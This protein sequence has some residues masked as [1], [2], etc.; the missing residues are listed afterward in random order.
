MGLFGLFSKKRK[1]SLKELY[2]PVLD[3]MW[4]CAFRFKPW[5]PKKNQVVF[6]EV[7]IVRAVAYKEGIYV[8]S[9]ECD[10]FHKETTLKGYIDTI[11]SDW[12][13]VGF[14]E[15]LDKAKAE[16]CKLMNEWIAEM[17][18]MVKNAEAS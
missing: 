12:S 3:R 1:M 16:Y 10:P 2:A 9:D 5:E 13:W 8:E 15:S 11:T 17:Q 6:K 4:V 18:R 14:F 7:N